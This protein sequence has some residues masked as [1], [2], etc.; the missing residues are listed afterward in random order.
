MNLIA[1]IKL[2]VIDCHDDKTSLNPGSGAKTKVQQIPPVSFKDSDNQL[3]SAE[4]NAAENLI[5]NW[6][7]G[8]NNYFEFSPRLR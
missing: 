2:I 6:D 4:P 3:N 1:M 8:N 5:Q 7:D